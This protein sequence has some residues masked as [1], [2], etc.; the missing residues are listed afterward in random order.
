MTWL[1]VAHT[2]TRSAEVAAPPDRVWTLITDVAAF[3]T[4]RPDVTAVDQLSAGAWRVT[5]D[6]YLRALRG[7]IGR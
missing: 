4:L 2:A 6:A 1:P 5:I 7:H 3:P